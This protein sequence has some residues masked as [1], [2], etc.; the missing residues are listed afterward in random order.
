MILTAVGASVCASG[1]QLCSGNNG[2]LIAKPIKKIKKIN[3]DGIII[4]KVEPDTPIKFNSAI[5]YI[6]KVPV[7]K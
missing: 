7:A 2:N 1:S 5:S 6:T 4:L 3:N